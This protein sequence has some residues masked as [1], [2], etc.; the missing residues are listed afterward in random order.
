MSVFAGAPAILLAVATLACWL[1]A[2]R[3]SKVD[4]MVALR[5]E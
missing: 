3:A 4:P 5:H 2:Q 1:P